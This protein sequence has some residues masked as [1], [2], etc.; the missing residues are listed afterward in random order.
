MN[1]S[2]SLL[3]Q[4]SP[5]PDYVADPR[6][7]S[8]HSRGVAID[9]TLI[10]STGNELEMGTPFDTPNPKSW[11]TDTSINEEAQ[12]NRQ[13]LKKIMLDSGWD[14]YINEWWHYQMFDARKKYPLIS[15]NDYN[16]KMM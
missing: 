5:N 13:T 3:K 6:R 4:T 12:T 15:D 2:L 7:G 11:H 9:L 16:T 1:Q 8:P 14:F 10:D